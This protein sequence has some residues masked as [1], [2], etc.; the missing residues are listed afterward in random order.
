MVEWAL[1]GT[2]AQQCL[3]KAAQAYLEDIFTMIANELAQGTAAKV[4]SHADARHRVPTC[5]T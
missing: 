1:D 2:S 3:R 4:I 5:R